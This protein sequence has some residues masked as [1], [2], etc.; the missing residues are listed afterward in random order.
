MLCDMIDVGKDYWRLLDKT[1]D[2]LPTTSGRCDLEKIVK[3]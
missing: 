1:S 3:E 2:E